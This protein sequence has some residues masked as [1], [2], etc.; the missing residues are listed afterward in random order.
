MR[1]KSHYPISVKLFRDERKLVYKVFRAVQPHKGV[2]VGVC[3]LEGSFLCQEPEQLSSSLVV[4]ERIELVLDETKNLNAQRQDGTFLGVLPYTDAVLPKMMME[5]GI[6]MFGY[7][8]A[9]D[10]IEDL[11]VITISLYCE[12]Y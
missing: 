12:K 8:E 11:L 7:F 9:K 5:R 2:F 10:F 3:E 4:G 6:K 1:L